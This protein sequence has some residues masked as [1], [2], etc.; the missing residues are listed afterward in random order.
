MGCFIYQNVRTDMKE[1]EKALTTKIS[2][3]NH[4]F[5]YIRLPIS[6]LDDCVSVF[7]NEI[8]EALAMGENV[9]LQDFGTFIVREKEARSVRNPNTDGI[10]NLP[11][12][13]CVTFR[14]SRA[15]KNILNGESK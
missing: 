1:F 11:A 15:L 8:S 12:S 3:G 5:K 4:I 13:R 10:V 7:F 9:K 6:T 2:L 14:S